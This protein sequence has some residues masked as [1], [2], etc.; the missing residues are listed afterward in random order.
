[1]KLVQLAKCQRRVP[2][3]S[4]SY[5]KVLS[6]SYCPVDTTLPADWPGSPGTFAQEEQGQGSLA[7]T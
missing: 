5:P 4:Q 3:S 6:P 1:M 2:N 7:S